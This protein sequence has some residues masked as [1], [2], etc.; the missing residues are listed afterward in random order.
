MTIIIL[1]INIITFALYGIDKQKA[2]KHK[3]R[4]PEAVLLIF[5]WIGGGVG[6]LLGMLC[7][8]HKARKWKSRIMVPLSIIVRIT[9][10]AIVNR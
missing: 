2:V 6:A 5:P 7:F 1:I 8:H 10:A 3:W 9:A 4:I